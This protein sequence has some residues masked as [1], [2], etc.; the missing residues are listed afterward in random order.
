MRV[1]APRYFSWRVRG[2]EIFCCVAT[3]N[4][5]YSSLFSPPQISLDAYRRKREII[6]DAEYEIADCVRQG[7]GDTGYTLGFFSSAEAITGLTGVSPG[8]FRGKRIE[9]LCSVSHIVG[10]KSNKIKQELIMNRIKVNS[11]CALWS[12]L[13]QRAILPPKCV[14]QRV[15]VNGVPRYKYGGF[16]SSPPK[17]A[18]NDPFLG[19]PRPP[20][21]SKHASAR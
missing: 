11:R 13:D 17:R 8:Y 14:G 5:K 2:R 21:R 4:C 3:A 12:R 20:S 15:A 10:Q 6:F 9:G 7:C 1:R 18:K 19:F 16:R